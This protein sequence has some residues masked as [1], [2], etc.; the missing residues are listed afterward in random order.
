MFSFHFQKETKRTDLPAFGV[1]CKICKIFSASGTA[2]F[3][4]SNT[5]NLNLTK[6]SKKLL[7][8]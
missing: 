2:Q 7:C 5:S 3:L 4:K 1:L 6:A 8:I